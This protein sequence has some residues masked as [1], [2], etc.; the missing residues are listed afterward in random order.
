MTVRGRKLGATAV[1]VMVGAAITAGCGGAVGNAV[2]PKDFA[3]SEAVKGVADCG[4]NPKAERPLTVDL[5]S[6]QRA[7]VE[8]AVAAGLVVVAYDCRSFR[9]LSNCQL[10]DAKYSYA[11]VSRKE[12]LVQLVSTDDVS[13]T[14][15]INASKFS[16]EVHS[17]RALDLALITVGRRSTT[18]SKLS[19][20][21]LS[22]D[23]EGATH[24]VSRAS[25]GAF[26]M[27]TGSAGKAAAAA[28][29][30]GIGSAAGASASERSATTLDGSLDACRTGS[31]KNP[32]PPEEC[33]V[34]VR[35]E[36]VPLAKAVTRTDKSDRPL[37]PPPEASTCPPGFRSAGGVCSEDAAVAYLC[38]PEKFAECETQCG[39]GNEG[40]CF[41]A[42]AYLLAHAEN[43][44]EAWEKAYLEAK[45]FFEKGCGSGHVEACGSLARVRFPLAVTKTNLAEA[46]EAIALAKTACEGGSVV[47]CSDLG[48]WL[49]WNGG[50]DA[51]DTALVDDR[52]SLEYAERACA[53]GSYAECATAADYR[54]EKTFGLKKISAYDPVRAVEL[55]SAG[56]AGGDAFVCA[57]LTEWV[58]SGKS[59]VKKDL[60]HAAR[61][62]ERSCQLDPELCPMVASLLERAGDNAS[63][64]KLRR[65]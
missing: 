18:V 2:R 3:A 1:G 14:L 16:A 51:V 46:R 5:D 50:D 59:G 44:P 17:G 7:D 62:A 36:L 12:E 56:C 38:D 8:V 29:V 49:A 22:G 43:R 41:N 23:C 31:A 55:W 4:T 27:K 47:A 37:P 42:G 30:F 40:S 53:L 57:L 21:E 48:H 33:E 15:P 58:S 26:A 52:G 39:R 61:A 11:G 10:P 35:L 34:P 63:A 60:P 19:T 13:A 54:K 65:R 32:E 28:D 24:F 64:E 6:D 9:V 45:P 20:Q 25:I